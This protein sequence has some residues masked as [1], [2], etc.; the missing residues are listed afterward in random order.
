MTADKLPEAW[1][2]TCRA[3]VDARTP[4][5]T[6]APRAPDAG[7]IG[8]CFYCGAVNIYTDDLQLRSP[9]PDELAVLQQN[10]FIMKAARLAPPHLRPAHRH[11]GDIH[12][13][14]QCYRR[15]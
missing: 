7:D 1:C 3:I 12:D 8:I 14:N 2:P 11:L 6:V 4:I 10:P 13:P 15:R 5:G 9:T